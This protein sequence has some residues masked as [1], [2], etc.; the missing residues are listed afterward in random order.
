MRAF[1]FIALGFLFAGCTQNELFKVEETRPVSHPTETSVRRWRVQINPEVLK[2]GKEVR[3][4]FVPPKGATRA[5]KLK[6]TLK[7]IDEESLALDA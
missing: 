1:V 5:E 6:L 4:T 3:L 2:P 7:P